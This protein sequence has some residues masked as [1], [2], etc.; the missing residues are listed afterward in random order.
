MDFDG[1]SQERIAFYVTGVALPSEESLSG[2][3]LAF[4][5]S[6][7]G[8]RAL[9]PGEIA[10]IC[11]A[12]EAAPAEEEVLVHFVSALFPSEAERLLV[13][14]QTMALI[15]EVR[16]PDCNGHTMVGRSLGGTGRCGCLIGKELECAGIVRGRKRGYFLAARGAYRKDDVMDPAA[17]Q[18][19]ITFLELVAKAENT[20]TVGR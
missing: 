1:T 9:T 11:A 10:T 3:E 18:V 13:L 6:E 5:P 12:R 4:R 17:A 2:L 7:T 19:R 20:V 15:E 16:D 8:G 14:R